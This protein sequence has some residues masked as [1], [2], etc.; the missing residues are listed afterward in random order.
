M[1][2]ADSGSNAIRRL[3]LAPNLTPSPDAEDGGRRI[4]GRLVTLAG[5]RGGEEGR[6]FNQRRTGGLP[7][8]EMATRDVK[9]QVG[10]LL[11]LRL[12]CLRACCGLLLG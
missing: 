2:I 5:G 11:S 4:V 10:T 1:V 6:S 3:T 9:A 7:H 8:A 12:L